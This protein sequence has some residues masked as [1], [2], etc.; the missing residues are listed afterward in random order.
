MSGA[1]VAVL[2]GGASSERS[3]SLASGA[4]VLEALHRVGHDARCVDPAQSDGGTEFLSH[5]AEVGY[6]HAFI[7]LHGGAG[8]NGELQGALD[9]AAM[10]YTGSGVL[11]AALAMDKWRS[12]WLWHGLELPVPRGELLTQDSDWSAVLE[13]LGAAAV[14]KPSTGGS[15]I[16]IQGVENPVEMERAWS[17]ARHHN[18]VVMAEE[19]VRGDEYTV[20]IVGQRTLPVVRIV[21][22]APFYDFDAKYHD[23]ATELRC[24][25]G[26]SDLAERQAQEL[27]LAAFQALGCS[28]WGRVDLLYEEPGRGFLL[29]EVNAVPGMTE[30]S[31]LPL[32]AH[33]SGL[34][35]D[36]LVLSV[37][38]TAQCGAR[39]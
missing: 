9:S 3:I 25:S 16:G 17:E 18:D 34:D 8:E 33:H 36:Q 4:A 30:H 20:G 35:F 23:E 27:S 12:K 39:R 28:G 21:P 37:L 31:L 38:E 29:L 1:G 22:D 19:W 7:S 10:P 14:V 5:L 11:G 15:S 26:L 2:S 24:P 6:D 32:A 13:R